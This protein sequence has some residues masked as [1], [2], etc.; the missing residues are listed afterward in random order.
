[1]LVSFKLVKRAGQFLLQSAEQ[2]QE[3]S[4]QTLGRQV[5]A[6]IGSS[7]KLT[8]QNFALVPDKSWQ[9]ANRGSG[10]GSVHAIVNRK[11]RSHQSLVWNHHEF[12]LV[13]RKQRAAATERGGPGHHGTTEWLPQFSWE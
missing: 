1:V 13:Q 4:L 7:L 10:S 6:A 12:L 8:K 5:P 9:V 11:R 2:F 3:V